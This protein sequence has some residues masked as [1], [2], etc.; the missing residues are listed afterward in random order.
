[1]SRKVGGGGGG[2]DGCGQM[3]RCRLAASVVRSP[4]RR[5]LALRGGRGGRGEMEAHGGESP[6]S[7][8]IHSGEYYTCHCGEAFEEDFNGLKKGSSWP[9]KLRTSAVRSKG[10]NQ[11][12]SK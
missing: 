12:N 1:M 6:I 2:G 7:R 8:P 4:R 9:D 5:M 3:R 11:Q 10:R